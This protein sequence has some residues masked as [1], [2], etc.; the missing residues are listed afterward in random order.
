MARLA[1]EQIIHFQ[2]FGSQINDWYSS[3]AISSCLPKSIP[4]IGEKR[5]F[6]MPAAYMQHIWWHWTLLPCAF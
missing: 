4:E 6:P 1:V 2:T 3:E 5:P